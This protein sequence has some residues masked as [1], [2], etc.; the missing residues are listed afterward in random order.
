MCCFRC[1]IF[2]IA[3][4]KNHQTPFR[5][6]TNILE[7]IEL[8]TAQGQ[9]VVITK[10]V[11]S[12]RRTKIFIAERLSLFVRVLA[13]PQRV[14]FH[15]F[16]PLLHASRPSLLHAFMVVNALFAEATSPLWSWNL[17][18]T[19]ML[20]NSDKTST[21][22]WPN[23]GFRKF[24]LYLIVSILPRQRKHFTVLRAWNSILY[25]MNHGSWSLS[26]SPRSPCSPW[27][28]DHRNPSRWSAPWW[29][30]CF[31]ASLLCYKTALWKPG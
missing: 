24:E 11:C 30:R 1:G 12:D 2:G 3:H 5:M 27:H 17:K 21:F 8:L 9:M 4:S 29:R 13:L 16:S 19:A 22:P 20:F 14:V 23:F 25:T 15:H 10:L 28:H 7:I 31:I 6:S 26:C 18:V